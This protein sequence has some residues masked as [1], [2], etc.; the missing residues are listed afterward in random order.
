M[1]IADCGVTDMTPQSFKDRTFRFVVEIC[2]MVGRLLSG[3]H[4]D[5]LHRQWIR[6]ATSVSANSR[7]ALSARSKNEFI[8]TMGVVEEACDEIM[9]W[10]AMMEAVGAAPADPL[11]PNSKRP[12]SCWP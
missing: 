11:A 1:W 2:Q 3:R 8:S 12:A 9:H 7:S 4:Q 10:L 5:I 6:S